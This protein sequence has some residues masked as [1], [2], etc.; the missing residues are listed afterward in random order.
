MLIGKNKRNKPGKEETVR[1]IFIRH[2]H[3]NYTK[4]CLTEIGR[5]QAAAAA[6]RLKEG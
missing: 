4:D 3:P 5:K 2:A 1:I 6:K